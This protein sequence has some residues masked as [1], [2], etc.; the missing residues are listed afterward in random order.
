MDRRRALLAVLAAAEGHTY[1][2]VQ[3]QKAIFLISRNIPQA[4]EGRP[5]RFEPY[6]YGPFDAEVY[7]EAEIL[8]D[9]GFADITSSP[10]GRWK[11]YAASQRGILEGKKA[12]AELSPQHQKYIIEVVSW[13]RRLGFSELVKSI[14][15]AYPD[16]KANSIFQN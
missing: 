12:L 13:V 14:Y 1:Q 2:P 4:I 7:H 3:L 11:L 8:R 10:N 6:D 16:M 5:F 15:E 9:E